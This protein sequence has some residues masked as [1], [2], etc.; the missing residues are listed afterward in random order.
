MSDFFVRPLLDD[1]A[2]R[3]AIGGIAFHDYGGDPE[4]SMGVLH[5]ENPSLPFYATERTILSAAGLSRLV[6]QLRAGARCYNQWTTISDEFGGPHQFLGNSFVYRDPLPEA[7]RNFLYV[8]RDDASDFRRSPAWGLFGQFTRH[9][10][11]GMVRID[12]TGGDDGWVRAV[13]FR[14][15]ATGEIA[16]VTVNATDS[17]QAF[18]LRCGGAEAPTEQPARSVASWRFTPGPLCASGTYP[19]AD[20]PAPAAR[21]DPAWDIAVEDV[22]LNGPAR[23]GADLP[24]SC[25]VRNV[26]DAPVPPEATIR[27]EFHLDGDLPIARAI[28]SLPALAPGET[29]DIAANIPLGQP[30]HFRT[31]WRAEKGH[32]QIFAR[33][34]VGN[35]RAERNTHNNVFAREFD[36]A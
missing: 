24:L 33:A 21:L 22:R 12:C 8:P 6:R 7:R 36:F 14:D 17:A 2:A 23:A 19:V 13:A 10:R 9:L 20:V 3:A 29:A 11:P 28:R 5:R 27:V 26:G 1:P 15:D 30:Y 34:S 18:T 35:V 4:P 32:H 16:V 25:V 31:A